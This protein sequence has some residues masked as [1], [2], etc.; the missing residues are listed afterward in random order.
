MSKIQEAIRASRKSAHRAGYAVKT[1]TF[2]KIDAVPSTAPLTLQGRPALAL[3]EKQME[4]NCLLPF[5]TTKGA[6]NAYMLLRTRL[7]QRMRENGWQSLMVTGTVPDEGKTTTAINV[8]IGISHDVNQA[9]LLVDLDLDRPSIAKSL[10]L[11]QTT[12]LSDYLRGDADCKDVLYNTDVKR[13]FVLPNF[14]AISSADSL[15]TP[16]M[17]ALFDYIKQLESKPLVIFDMPPILSS[18]SV[19]AIAP[20]IDALLFVISEGR[21]P[22]SLLK[23]ASQMIEEIPRAG[24]VLNRSTEGDTG[25]YY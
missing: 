23:R 1:G 6:T 20:H 5:V 10:G 7:M 24:T 8:A 11:E 12:G 2:P 16:R 13:L 21:T 18:D 4:R 3:D 25:A 17:L 19:L 9:V 14:E 22:R 15:T